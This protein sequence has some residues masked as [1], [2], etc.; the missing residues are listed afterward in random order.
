[1]DFIKKLK[2]IL[3]KILLILDLLNKMVLNHLLDN[4]QMKSYIMQVEEQMFKICKSNLMYFI[5]FIKDEK[6]TRSY[7]ISYLWNDLALKR[8]NNNW[9]SSKSLNTISFSFIFKKENEDIYLKAFR[10]SNVNRKFLNKKFTSII[11]NF[12]IICR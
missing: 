1:M 9:Y 10:C 5:L 2:I 7:I 11:L 3:I 6:K 4:Q 12:R 8:F